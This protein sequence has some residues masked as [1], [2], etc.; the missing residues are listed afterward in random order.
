MV[1]SSDPHAAREGSARGGGGRARGVWTAKGSPP[2]DAAKRGL[3]PPHAAAGDG[4]GARGDGDE[5]GARTVPTAA[6]VR[7]DVE[8][9]KIDA[10]GAD[11]DVVVSAG[12]AVRW[13]LRER[14]PGRVPSLRS[15]AL[16]AP[17]CTLRRR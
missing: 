6:A 16:D 15:S 12:A 17:L 8:L 3:R 10:Q 13:R 7:L 14:A 9:V 11:L 5:R 1:G 4:G 2:P